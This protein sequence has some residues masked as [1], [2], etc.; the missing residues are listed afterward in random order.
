MLCRPPSSEV[1]LRRVAECPPCPPCL[2]IQ[3]TTTFVAPTDPCCSETH[4][5]TID[6]PCQDCEAGCTSTMFVTTTAPDRRD[7]ICK[8]TVWISSIL[9]TA[10]TTTY[11]PLTQ[12]IT[13][14]VQCNGCS[15]VVSDV[16]G[17]GPVVKPTV[18]VTDTVPA[19]VTSYA[20]H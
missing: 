19:V 18:T 10:P 3:T 17:V 20:C 5:K 15:L 16:N 12:T 13:S 4:T 14:L 6:G 7:N 11:H 2:E 1:L 8:T 9:A